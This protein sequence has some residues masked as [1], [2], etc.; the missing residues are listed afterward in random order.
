MPDEKDTQPTLYTILE[1]LEAF[2]EE[3]LVRFAEIRLMLQHIDDKLDSM[4]DRL[5]D[6]EGY[7]R[8][9]ARRLTELELRK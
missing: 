1:K 2:R 7:R 3:V 4:N 6:L 8:E 5:T 9:H